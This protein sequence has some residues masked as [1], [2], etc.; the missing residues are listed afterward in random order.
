MT[1]E[2]LV[3]GSKSKLGNYAVIPLG[4]P[5]TAPRIMR[6]PAAVSA[7]FLFRPFLLGRS[8]FRRPRGCHLPHPNHV[9][10]VEQQE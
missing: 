4:G 9:R 7:A 3:N 10:H 5:I 2:N 6:R 1:R 8:E